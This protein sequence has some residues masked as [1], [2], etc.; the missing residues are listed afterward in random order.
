[1]FMVLHRFHG[2]L[3]LH[4]FSE[5]LAHF[6]A[7]WRLSYPGPNRQDTWAKGVACPASRGRRQA[8]HPLLTPEDGHSRTSPASFACQTRRPPST[9]RAVSQPPPWQKVSM[10]LRYPRSRISPFFCGVW[11][12]T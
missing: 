9:S 6:L 12:T 11:P 1:M 2:L 5:F 8:P 4:H 3:V 10:H 7:L